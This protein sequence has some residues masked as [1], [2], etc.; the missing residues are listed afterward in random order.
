[1]SVHSSVVSAMLVMLV[2]PSFVQA[3]TATGKSGYRTG[4]ITYHRSNGS[5]VTLPLAVWYPTRTPAGWVQDPYVWGRVTE[6]APTVPGP[7]PLIVHSH[8][9]G[10]CAV[11]SGYLNEALANAGYIVAAVDHDDAADCWSM[12]ARAP[13]APGISSSRTTRTSRSEPATSGLYS[14]RCCRVQPG[15]L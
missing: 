7:W 10:E 1:M 5:V 6:N 12:A 8:G 13:G 2:Q 15:H 14:T 11:A 4:S 3:Q 9:V